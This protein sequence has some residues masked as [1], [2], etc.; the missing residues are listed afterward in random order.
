M[1]KFDN[2]DEY[3]REKGI[4]PKSPDHK[5]VMNMILRHNQAL[6]DLKN[7]PKSTGFFGGNFARVDRD[8][9]QKLADTYD[10]EYSEPVVFT[11]PHTADRL[12]K[13]ISEVAHKLHVQIIEITNSYE[14]DKIPI[15][16]S[17]IFWS[18]QS[19][20]SSSRNEIG[21]AIDKAI[22]LINKTNFL[23]EPLQKEVAMRPEDGV[24]PIDQN[25]PEKIKAS[26]IFI[27]DLTPIYNWSD[28]TDSRRILYPNPNI[29]IEVGY[30]LRAMQKNQIILIA[31][32]RVEEVYKHGQFPFDISHR[33]IISYGENDDLKSLV[34]EAIAT[35]LNV[36]GDISD[37]E[38]KQLKR[39]LKKE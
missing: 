33:P 38:F 19:H 21:A 25:I 32:K 5:R 1:E 17:Q 28:D 10:Y 7:Y 27:G 36:L 12:K 18:W 16:G 29:C 34:G 2:P 3:L 9:L 6:E 13:H 15:S 4:D 26:R 11:M 39:Q 35:S 8:K 23:K 22:K 14:T 30:A 20:Y 31:K 24:N 37:E